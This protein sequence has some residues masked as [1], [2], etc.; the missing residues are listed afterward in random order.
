MLKGC[1]RDAQRMLNGCFPDASRILAS[2]RP[3][4]GHFSDHVPLLAALNGGR[5]SRHLLLIHANSTTLFAIFLPCPI[6]NCRCHNGCNF[7][8]FVF[9]CATRMP[10]QHTLVASRVPTSPP[11]RAGL[12][13][14]EELAT[15]TS[16]RQ[17]DGEKVSGITRPYSDRGD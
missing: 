2:S 1:L 13:G 6:S 10:A 5:K 7:L 14:R 11:R 8:Y 16:G 17:D 15:R 12:R 3:R 9:G 4:H